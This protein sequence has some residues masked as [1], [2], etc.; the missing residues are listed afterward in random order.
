MTGIEL[1]YDNVLEYVGQFGCFQ[2]KVFLWMCLVSF[3]T[4]P[5]IVVFAFTG[6]QLNYRCPIT[7][8]GET[9]HS[10]YF[11][12]ETERQ[13]P[14]FYQEDSIKLSDRCRLPDAREANVC[15]GGDTKLSFSWNNSAWCSPSDLLY[16][17]SLVTSSLVQE[18]DLVCH[19]SYLTSVLSSLYML[20]A[21]VGSYLFGWISDKSGRMKSLMLACLTCSLSGCLGAFCGGS[22]G[23]Y[24]YGILRFL[25]GMG[26]IGAFVTAF[27]LAVEHAGSRFTMLLGVAIMIPFSMGEVALGLA[28][29]LFRDWK[30][31]QIVTHLPLLGLLLLYRIVPESPRWL[32]INGRMKEAKAIISLVGKENRRQL[33]DHLLRT[34]AKEGETPAQTP[35]LTD[36][37]V[38]SIFKSPRMAL[39]TLNMCYQ[40]FSV[41]MCYYGLSFAS[42]SLS[43]D[44]YKIFVLNCLIEIPGHLFCMFTMDC[45]G[46]RPILSFCQIFSGVSCIVCGLLQGTSDTNLQLVQVILSMFGKFGAAACFAIVFVY[47]AEMFPTVI[48]NQAVGTCSL[49][50]RMGGI[51]CLLLDL[52]KVYWLPAPVFIMGV[53]A[54]SAGLLAT[55]FPETLGE[56]LPETME[57]AFRFGRKTDRGLCTFTCVDIK[58]HYGEKLKPVAIN[59]NTN[60]GAV[61]E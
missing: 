37:S 11:A 42:T 8:C 7:L 44:P 30:L 57:D 6:Y 48:R 34:K 39:R 58:E 12:N 14:T 31:L 25:T 38:L 15:E 41:T 45:W 43:D 46:R 27:V 18:F 33:P 52:L 3:L 17:H 19:R 56:E 59:G 40:W 36:S 35:A 51:L 16:D 9:S 55:L 28:A 10:T 60:N 20:G 29:Y 4:G 49:V 24:G 23:M 2:R 13:L 1:N 54:T 50:A 32:I 21:L 61:Q 5:P 53:V 22:L 47:T 26:G